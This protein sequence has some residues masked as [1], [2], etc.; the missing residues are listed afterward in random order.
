MSNAQFGE[1]LNKLEKVYFRLDVTNTKLDSLNN[2][3]GTVETPNTLNYLIKELNQERIGDIDTAYTLNALIHKLRGLM[4]ASLSKVFFATNR[5]SYDE[6]V[7]DIAYYSAKLYILSGKNQVIIK[8]YDLA[9]GTISDFISD[10]VPDYDPTHIAIDPRNKV[11]YV[12]LEKI[13]YMMIRKYD[14]E[15]GTLLDSKEFTVDDAH[16]IFDFTYSTIHEKLYCVS[17]WLV[18]TIDPSTWEIE[19]KI[20]IPESSENAICFVG[21]SFYLV[22]SDGELFTKLDKNL[23][24][25][26][27]LS[28]DFLNTIANRISQEYGLLVTLFI[29]TMVF[30]DENTFYIRGWDGINSKGYIFRFTI[31][32]TSPDWW[33]N[34]T[35]TTDDIYSKLDSIGGNIGITNFPT[36]F[37]DSTKLTDDIINAINSQIDTKTSVLDSR[38][39]NS[40]D[41]KSVYDHLKTIA[42]AVVDGKFLAEWA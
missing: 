5:W 2:K 9:Q 12:S 33:I 24:T 7:E 42:S 16:Y 28:Q 10:S 27:H 8:I 20:K 11:I 22:T 26:Y 4:G 1:L 23:D 21:D 34:S 31:L 38:L 19:D 15:A 18:Y 13:G 35:K 40:T 39:Y 29:S 14:L 41:S 25:E 17:G 37:T 30:T 32:A 3:I 36:W 6:T